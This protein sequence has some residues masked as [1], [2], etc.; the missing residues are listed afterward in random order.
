[1]IL[2]LQKAARHYIF[3]YPISDLFVDS[4]WCGRVLGVEL[5]SLHLLRQV[6]YHLSYFTNTFGGWLFL[7]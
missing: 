3:E 2:S 5:M 4:F 1:M 7:R 6:L